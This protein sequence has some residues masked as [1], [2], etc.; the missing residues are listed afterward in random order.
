MG[1]LI[2]CSQMLAALPYYIDSAALNVY[3]IEEL[4]YYI[5]H[6]LFLLEPDFMSEELCGWM[7]REL[8]LRETAETLRDIRRRKGTLAEFVS[9]ILEQSGYCSPERIRQIAA[10]LTE[11]EHKSEYECG[12]M[13]ADRYIQNKRYLSGISEYRRLLAGKDEKNEVLVG[14]VWHNLGKAYACLFLFREAADCFKQA[15]ERNQNPESL[16]ECLYAH[17]LLQDEKGFRET[18]KEYGLSE[19]EIMDLGREFTEKVR[20]EDIRQFEAQIEELFAEGEEQEICR[21]VDEWKETYR[22]NCRI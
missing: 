14:N 20:T 7:E 6:N 17:R 4:S 22:K 1:E 10:A 15:Y 16:R 11:L 21:L 9:C 2:L 13:R 8:K 5:E 18:A 3:S 19:E 12:K